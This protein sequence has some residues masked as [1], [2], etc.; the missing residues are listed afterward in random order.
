[1][2]NREEL[3]KHFA[4]LGFKKGAE[5]GIYEGRYS[6]VLLDN[7]PSLE[8]FCIDSWEDKRHQKLYPTAVKELEFYSGATIIRETSLEAA[9]EIKDGSLDFVFIDA[10]HDYKNVK[11]DIEVWSPK[12]RIGGIVSGHDYYPFKSGS[13]GVIDAVNEY[14]KNNNINLRLTS[15]DK[16]NVHNDDKPPCWWY[17]KEDSSKKKTKNDDLTVIFYT[18]NFIGEEFASRIRKQLVE[19]IKGLPLITV[20]QKPMGMEMFEGHVGEYKNICVGDIGRNHFNI[21]LQALAGAK[22]AKTKYIS[23][24]EDDILYSP[25]HFEHVSSP[26]KFAYDRSI[27]GIYTWTKPPVFSWKGRRNLW[28]LICERELFIEAMEER[29]AKY[30]IEMLREELAKKSKKISHLK[31]IWSEPGKYEGQLGV[32]VRDWEFYYADQPSVQFS[33]PTSLGY[34]GLGERKKLGEIQRE[35]LEPWG[36]CEKVLSIYNNKNMNEEKKEESGILS[37]IVKGMSPTPRKVKEMDFPDALREVIAGKKI[38][39]L[40]WCNKE[41]VVFL[42]KEILTIYKGDGKPYQL[43][44]SEGDLRGEDWVV[45]D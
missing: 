41:A 23:L 7:I 8:L 13:T 11:A 15:Y 34:L 10:A 42:E 26:G 29:F 36:N 19:S 24:V 5:I 45:I 35:N 6:K 9:K 28:T 39:K 14:V 33:H 16:D 44:L 18:C 38:T 22:E 2:K 4:E 30:P 31:K 43:I 27:W 3:A 21:Y 1:M 40:E 32:R 37:N 20:S 12:V 25:E 17:I